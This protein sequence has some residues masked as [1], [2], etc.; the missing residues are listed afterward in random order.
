MVEQLHNLPLSRSLSASAG[1]SGYPQ[2]SRLSDHVC[3]RL[4]YLRW[5]NCRILWSEKVAHSYWRCQ[6]HEIRQLVNFLL[7][8]ASCDS[9]VTGSHWCWWWALAPSARAPSLTHR[10]GAPTGDDGTTV[11]GCAMGGETCGRVS[12]DAKLLPGGGQGMS[13]CCQA[14]LV[15]VE[16]EMCWVPD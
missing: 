13:G 1:H 7:G 9:S 3:P 5:L 16:I 8:R 15:G 2:S 10:W 12:G 6:K 11:T 4:T 14:I